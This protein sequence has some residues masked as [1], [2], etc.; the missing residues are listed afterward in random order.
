MEEL[1]FQFQ[2]C[3]ALDLDV[4]EAGVTEARVPVFDAG[5]SKRVE[6]IDG[7][8]VFFWVT[9][10]ASSRSSPVISLTWSPGFPER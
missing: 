10:P 6:K 9:R 5:A 1:A 4:A 2:R 8:P 7:E 3:D